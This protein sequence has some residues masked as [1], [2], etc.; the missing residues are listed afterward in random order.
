[1]QGSNWRLA[2][3]ILDFKFPCPDTNDPHWRRYGNDSAYSNR[4]QDEV[5]RE[6]LGGK[7]AILSPQGF[8][9]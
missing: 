4:T 6:A 8:V 2:A 7:T 3:L 9:P 1:M 5:Y